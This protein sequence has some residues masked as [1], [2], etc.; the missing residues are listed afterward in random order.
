M[1]RIEINHQVLSSRIVEFLIYGPQ[2]LTVK[3]VYENASSLLAEEA[4]LRA[5]LQR[6]QQL[7]Q[8]VQRDI[9]KLNQK[10]TS[11]NVMSS[12][13]SLVK[14]TVKQQLLTLGSKVEQLRET[15]DVE[16]IPSI[17]HDIVQVAPKFL[18]PKSKIFQLLQS[19]TMQ[20]RTDML[21]DFH[22]K[23]ESHLSRI[24]ALTSY[25]AQMSWEQ[26]LSS[27]RQW[28]VAFTMISILPCLFKDSSLIVDHYIDA[29]DAAMGPLWARCHFHLLTARESGTE[30]QLLWTFEYMRSFVDLLS[31]MCMALSN[32]QLLNSIHSADFTT[33]SMNYIVNKATRFM[34]AHIA[35]AL[36][37]L[38]LNTSTLMPL[39]EYTLELDGHIR[40]L[41]RPSLSIV[42]VFCD[43]KLLLSE[44]VSQDR[45]YF[46]YQLNNFC[47]A[48]SA[49]SCHFASKKEKNVFCFASVYDA[50]H[51]LHVAH[52]RYAALPPDAAD[53]FV[54][55][56]IEPIL[57]CSLGFLLSYSHISPTLRAIHRNRLHDIAVC[58]SDVR[59]YISSAKYV[60]KSLLQ[61]S[62]SNS[63]LPV[64][65]TLRYFN[66]WK[67]LKA[68]IPDLA[69]EVS[70]LRKV[71]EKASLL[72]DIASEL[73]TSS[74]AQQ[75]A[76]TLHDLFKFQIDQCAI[77]ISNVE[78]KCELD[79]MY[80]D[81]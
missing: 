19:T 80:S 54:L 38:S 16:V 17:V 55:F 64:K 7:L 4:T 18:S 42:G 60:M 25:S 35:S 81:T 2:D 56:V 72:S 65:N 9:S 73:A 14:D 68:W 75:A 63:T 15:S 10:L 32:Q 49:Y 45:E 77:L 50:L 33:A 37:S 1:T 78:S 21:S 67:T 3:S 6:H 61:L 70:G 44:W 41:Q 48:T 29:L 5:D 20:L 53:T 74:P 43:H 66:S 26:F 8:N 76:G 12:Y 34:R 69:K 13:Q 36:S 24:E 51:L 71:V 57:L 27:S 22:H 52:T 40:A 11:H 79:T 47:V 59:N 28:L 30:G 23:F 58:K 46:M 31:T 62:N 39:I